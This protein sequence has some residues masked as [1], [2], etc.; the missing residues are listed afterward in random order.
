MSFYKVTTYFQTDVSP[1]DTK[2]IGEKQ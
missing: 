2:L 1:K